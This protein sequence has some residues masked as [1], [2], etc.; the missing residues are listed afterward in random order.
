MVPISYDHG[1]DYKY[2]KD[3]INYIESIN[4][5]LSI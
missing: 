3:N 2:D 5:L 4:K 1:K